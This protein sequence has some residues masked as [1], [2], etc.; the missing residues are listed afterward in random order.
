VYRY[1]VVHVLLTINYM[2]CTCTSTCSKKK[3]IR[4]PGTCTPE[5]ILHTTCVCAHTLVS[6][7]HHECKNVLVHPCVLLH[8]YVIKLLSLQ[9]VVVH[10]VSKY[11]YM[12]VV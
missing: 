4:V 3:L 12:N 8:V 6:C 7:V 2:Y 11:T 10:V 5:C 1:R 9:W